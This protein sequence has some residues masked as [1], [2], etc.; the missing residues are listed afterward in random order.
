MKNQELAKYEREIRDFAIYYYRVFKWH[1]I[2]AI[3]AGIN[4]YKVRHA[5]DTQPLSYFE[6]KKLNGQ[7]RSVM[8]T[9]DLVYIPREDHPNGRG[10]GY[11]SHQI[12]FYDTTIQEWRSCLADRII[13][14]YF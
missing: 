7:I 12:R 9:K 10:G 6:F 3:R 8:A 1:P 11:T 13:R 2:R 5:L 4:L 14:V